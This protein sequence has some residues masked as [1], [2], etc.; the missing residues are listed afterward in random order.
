MKSGEMKHASDSLLE[1]RL[2]EAQCIRCSLFK[3]PLNLKYFY[4]LFSTDSRLRRG[5]CEGD[6]K[7]RGKTAAPVIRN[8]NNRIKNYRGRAR[9]CQGL[10]LR[11][12]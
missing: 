7:N 12:F 2:S 1:P 11:I 6:L 8:V 9:F 10:F 5:P 3:V 4:I